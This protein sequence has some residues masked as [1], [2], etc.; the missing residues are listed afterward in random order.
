MDKKDVVCTHTH[1]HTEWNTSQPLKE[2]RN[3]ICSNRDGYYPTIN[4]DII[5]LS[6]TDK[7]IIFIWNLKNST[8]EFIYNTETDSYR[9]T[10]LWLPEGNVGKE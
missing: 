1:T 4:L 8:P 3:V 7:Y 10:N 9:R 5:I 6:K 2:W